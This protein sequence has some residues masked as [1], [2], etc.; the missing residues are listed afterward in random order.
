MRQLNPQEMEMVSGGL[1][2]EGLRQSTNVV[3]WRY[4]PVINPG[5]GYTGSQSNRRY[6]N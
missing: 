1:Q 3:D 4:P 6:I 5:S 2:W